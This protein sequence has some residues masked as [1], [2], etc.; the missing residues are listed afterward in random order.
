MA[1]V[2]LFGL[3]NNSRELE[4][5]LCQ[6]FAQGVNPPP[7][8]VRNG[9]PTITRTLL[10]RLV[11]LQAPR[12][13][14]LRRSFYWLQDAG[15]R[16]QFLMRGDAPT[17]HAHFQY[18]RHLLA[19]NRQRIFSIYQGR[20][21]I[22]KAGLRDINQVS[23][24]AELWLY[25]GIAEKRGE[26]LGKVALHQLESVI[27]DHFG[28]HTA[29]LHVSRFNAPAYRL[30]CHSGYRLSCYQDAEAAGFMPGLDVVRMEKTL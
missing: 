27:R 10:Q 17:R 14:D 21:H 30:Y 7:D 24:Q 19:D 18:W 28:C 9:V 1:S 22:G 8:M 5:A 3:Y 26:G 12:P 11:S 2:G 23:G 20:R 6:A 13:L 4:D 25:L 16:Q 29:V 15:L